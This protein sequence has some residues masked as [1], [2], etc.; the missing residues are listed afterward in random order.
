[1]RDENDGV[2]R[3]RKGTQPPEKLLRFFRREHRGRF[4]ENE[5]AR[6][7]GECFHD[8]EPL[9]R[10]DGQAFDP[11][12]GIEG[13]ARAPGDV[14]DA[15]SCPLLVETSATSER[16]VLGDGHR[17]HVREVLMH[18]TNAGIDGVGRCPDDAITRRDATGIGCRQ[19]EGDAHER[20]FAGAVFSEEGVHGA[21]PNADGDVLEC[22][23]CSVALRDAGEREYYIGING[24]RHNPLGTSMNVDLMP[25]DSARR[26]PSARTPN[27][28]VA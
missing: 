3:R 25:N 20:R 6:I 27:V 17:R 13:Q 22:D 4:V 10:A 1:M 11:S 5:Y 28:S 18:H 2:S 24:V 15:V 16:D 8:L 21:A 26:S 14:R 23:G 19:T 12:F 9:L 7:V